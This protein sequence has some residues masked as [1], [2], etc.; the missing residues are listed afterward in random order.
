M[1]LTTPVEVSERVVNTTSTPPPALA[2]CSA[3]RSGSIFSPHSVSK[4]IVLAPWASQSSAQRCPN[5]P[6]EATSGVSPG[7]TRLATAD[8]MPPLP[9]ELNISTSFE[10]WNT[11]LSRSS[12]PS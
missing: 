2:S 9:E 4:W 11:I 7:A 12:T 6:Q 8:S 3:T 1:S 5:L 10:V